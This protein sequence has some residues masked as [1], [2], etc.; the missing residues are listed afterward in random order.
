[1]SLGDLE[2]VG[3]PVFRMSVSEH[4]V[5]TYDGWNKAAVDLTHKTSGDIRGMTAT[6]VFGGRLGRIAEDRHQLVVRTKMPVIHRL[7][8]PTTEGD[9]VFQTTLQPIIEDGRVVRIFGTS[10]DVTEAGDARRADAYRLLALEESE[11]FITMAAHDLRAPMRNVRIIAE[12]LKDGFEDLGD[13]KMALIDH[14]D[15]VAL[16]ASRL[17][18]DVLSHARSVGALEQAHE[19]VNL[20]EL[21]ADVFRVLDPLSE[22]DLQAKNCLLQ[23]ERPV[24]Q[25]IL[26][27]LVDNAIRHGDRDHLRLRI[28]AEGG[29]DMIRL[30]IEDDGRGFADPAIAFLDGGE[31]RYDSGFGLLGLRRMIETRGGR[32]SADHATHGGSVIEVLIPGRILEEE[33]SQASYQLDQDVM[34]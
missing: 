24:L 20:V 14:L 19:N 18:S 10:I 17:I 5:A 33:C 8:L 21:A 32:I 25:I 12:E 3:V 7:A 6:Q 23:A 16:K 22:H 34:S 29:D 1:M 28:S 9:R 31:F 30:R 27:N 2:N 13:G 11:R 15:Q 4:G 26:R